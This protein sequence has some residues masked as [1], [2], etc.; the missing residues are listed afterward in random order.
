MELAKIKQMKPDTENNWNWT[1]MEM[2]LGR[3]VNFGE[4][5]KRKYN[6]LLCKPYQSH[7]TSIIHFVS[8][9]VMIV[10]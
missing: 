4:G 8:L 7:S 2:E 3:I 5:E 9:I 6:V 1:G 10:N